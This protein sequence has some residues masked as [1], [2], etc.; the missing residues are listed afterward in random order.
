MAPQIDS[1]FNDSDKR[2]VERLDRGLTESS[3]PKIAD[4][5]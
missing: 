3:Q 2:K 4:L 1:S 5:L